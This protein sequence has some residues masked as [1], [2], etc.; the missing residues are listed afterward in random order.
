MPDA[1]RR[2]RKVHRSIGE[3]HRFGCAW[4][5]DVL[6]KLARLY[7]RVFQHLAKTENGTRGHSRALQLSEGLGGGAGCEP[8]LH[9]GRDGL[10]VVGAQKIVG[11]ARIVDQFLTPHQ[12]RPASEHIAAD[13][14]QNHPAVLGAVSVGGRCEKSSVASWLAYNSGHRSLGE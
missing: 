1:S 7:L 13:H 11:K 8:L 12:T 2:G 6:Q 5:I 4:I 3:W 10:A 14:L 9:C